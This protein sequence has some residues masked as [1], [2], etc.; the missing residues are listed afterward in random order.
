MV[1][2]RIFRPFETVIEPF[3]LD[4]P[5]LPDKGPLALVWH[6]A[7]HFRSVLTIVVCLSVVSSLIGLAVVWMLSLIHISEPTRPY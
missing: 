1:L 6:F 5:Q 2:D 7:R 4:I 3:D